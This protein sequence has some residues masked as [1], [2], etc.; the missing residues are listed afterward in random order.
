MRLIDGS[1]GVHYTSLSAVT[2]VEIFHI[3]KKG[4]H[5]GEGERDRAIKRD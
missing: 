2:Q 1:M 3:K 5:K 4:N